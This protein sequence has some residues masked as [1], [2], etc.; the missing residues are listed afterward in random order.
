MLVFDCSDLLVA[1]KI[2]SFVECSFSPPVWLLRKSILGKH[3]FFDWAIEWALK[4]HGPTR[5]DEGE[6]EPRK[7]N[8]FSKWARSRPLVLARGSNPGM[9]KPGPNPIRCHS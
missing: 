5:P 2:M 3:F 9:E 4:Y 8:P 1:E 6:S 7:K